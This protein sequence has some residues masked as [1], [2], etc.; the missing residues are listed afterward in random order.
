MKFELANPSDKIYLEGDDFEV[1]AIA[2]VAVGH[3]QYPA[4]EIDENGNEIDEGASVPFF[5][6]GGLDEWFNEKFGVCAEE[7]VKR[8]KKEKLRQLIDALRSFRCVGAR[9]SM[10]DICGYAHSIADA[11]EE[12][13]T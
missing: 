11:L 1:V 2:V 5:L 12:E 9:T 10:N 3:G 13:S 7:C 6:F 8:V 4:F